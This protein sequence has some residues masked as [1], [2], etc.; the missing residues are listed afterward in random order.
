MTALF[1][2][3]KSD[4]IIID[5]GEITAASYKREFWTLLIFNVVMFGVI[6]PFV[7]IEVSYWRWGV[8]DMLILIGPFTAGLMSFSIFAAL[9]YT[10]IGRK[11]VVTDKAIYAT[12]GGRYPYSEIKKI[13]RRPIAVPK[14]SRHSGY[15]DFPGCE[16]PQK[17][18]EFL[19]NAVEAA[20]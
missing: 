8:R 2:K 19:K 6:L 11:W 3:P 9:G 4:E 5:Q 17:L 15:I 1:Q 13:G 20:Q 7:F 14:N 12:N 10:M 18:R 16:N